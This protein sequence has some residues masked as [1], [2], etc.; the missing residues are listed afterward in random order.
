MVAPALVGVTVTPGQHTVVFQFKGYSSYP[1]LLLVGFL[2]LALFGISATFW[3]RN[4]QRLRR[5]R[6]QGDLAP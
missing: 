2:T 6:A 1:M 4:Y 5:G 3:R